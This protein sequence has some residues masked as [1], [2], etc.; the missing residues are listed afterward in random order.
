MPREHVIYLIITAIV[1]MI[2]LTL[3]GIFTGTSYQKQKQYQRLL[4]PWAK[5]KH[6][7]ECVCTKRGV[8]MLRDYGDDHAPLLSCS[9]IETEKKPATKPTKTNNSIV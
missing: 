2:S 6:N 3:L 4:C 1:C 9:S 8:V 5:C 7:K